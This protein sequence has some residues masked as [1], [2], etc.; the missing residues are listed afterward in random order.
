M[1]IKL[2]KFLFIVIAVLSSENVL[3]L[4]SKIN[5]ITIQ[6]KFFILRNKLDISYCKDVIISHLALQNIIVLTVCVL[7]VA[8]FSLIYQF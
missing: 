8:Y 6:K 3:F 5:I 2:N 7:K 1:M 4:F